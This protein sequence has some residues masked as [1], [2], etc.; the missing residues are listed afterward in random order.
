MIESIISAI[1]WFVIG[2]ITCIVAGILFYRWCIKELGGAEGLDE[3]KEEIM[4]SGIEAGKIFYSIFGN[5]E[6]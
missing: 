3:H 1:L 5:D 4:N 6:K 2:F